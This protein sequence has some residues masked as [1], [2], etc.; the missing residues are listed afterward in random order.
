MYVRLVRLPIHEAEN[1]QKQAL[2]GGLCLLVITQD[3]VVTATQ[4]HGYVEVVLSG[5]GAQLDT[6]HLPG[7]NALL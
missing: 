1:C 7:F 5:D 4:R 2:E 6:A 3:G